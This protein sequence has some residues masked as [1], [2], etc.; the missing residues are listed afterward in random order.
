MNES[1]NVCNDGEKTTIVI[2]EPL[3]MPRDNPI[4]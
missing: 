3:D 1:P 4:Q 2:A